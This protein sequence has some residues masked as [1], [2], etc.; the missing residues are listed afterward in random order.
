MTLSDV[1][2]SASKAVTPEKREEERLWQTHE[3]VLALL[4][5]SIAKSDIDSRPV[6]SLGGS[7]AKG[8]WLRGEADIDYFLQYPPSYPREELESEA[9][10]I[11]KKAVK[12]YEPNIRF[13]EHPYVEAHVDGVRVNLVPCYKVK[14]GE[15]QSAADRSPFHEEYI[16]SKFDDRLRL[17]ARLLKKFVK[18]GNI[19]GAEVKTQ[20]LSGYVCEVLTLKFGKFE[21]VLQ[22]IS[23]LSPGEVISIEP[24]NQDFASSFSSP[25]IILDPVDTTRNLGQAISVES[26]AR[27]MLRC[28]RFISNASE[29]FFTGEKGKHKMDRDLLSRV[30]VL[31][32]HNTPR[33]VDILWGQLYKSLGAL[34][35]KLKLGGFEIL[36]AAVASNERDESAFVF[37]FLETSISEFKR[38][39]G[40]EIYRADEVKKF[41]SKNK[42]HAIMTWVDEEGRTSAVFRNDKVKRSAIKYLTELLSSRQVAS[43]GISKTIRE[44]I[45]HGKKKKF[46]VMEGPVALRTIDS[47][48]GRW[49]RDS[50][51]SILSGEKELAAD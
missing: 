51:Y 20:G 46:V 34:S 35:N 50:I 2:A 14:K 1:L 42:N 44:E 11:C 47:E 24:Y 41:V 36:R 3:K 38:R 19:Y 15:W 25:M 32:F 5:E 43:V 22:N 12:Q 31:T 48:K 18:V 9:I 33:S 16:R 4:D 8:T 6:V 37:L 21:S 29:N 13:A 28:R 45:G 40:P 49:L 23:T 30:V 10:E 27:F 7:Y 17:H 26:A 39:A